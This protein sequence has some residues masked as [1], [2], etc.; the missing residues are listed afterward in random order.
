VNRLRGTFAIL[1]GFVLLAGCAGR[2]EYVR[3]AHLDAPENSL[4][5]EQSK[6]EVWAQIIQALDDRFFT[7]DCLDKDSGTIVLT[8]VGDPERYIDCGSITSYVKNLGGERTYSFPAAA[9]ATEYEL[10][11]WDGLLFITRQMILEG[12]LNV[13]I[14]ETDAT[15]TRVSVHARYA[16]TRTLTVRDTQGGSRI[17]SNTILFN[18]GQEGAF[19]G[20]GTCR[21]TGLL[22]KEVLLSATR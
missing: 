19:P 12:R 7:I 17:T 11:Q 3:P 20:T 4:T 15:R 5:V 22:E 16:V 21:P 13:T 18:S 8:Y 14:A 1:L 9:G 2:F 6:A 10:M